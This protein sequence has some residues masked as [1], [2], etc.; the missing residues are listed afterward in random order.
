MKEACRQL[1]V[2]IRTLDAHRESEHTAEARECGKSLPPSETQFFKDNDLLKMGT[3]SQLSELLAPRNASLQRT[4]RDVP[5]CGVRS[6]LL[7]IG[8]MLWL[9]V[10]GTVF[11]AASVSV[12]PTSITYPTVTVGLGAGNVVYV[13]NTGSTV[14]TITKVNVTP[15]PQFYVSDGLAPA[16][17]YPGRP[18]HYSIRFVPAAAQSYSGQ[19]QAFLSDGSNV[20]VP[21]SGTGVTTN[22]VASLSTPSVNFVNQPLGTVSGPQ[23][24]TISDTGSDPFKIQA[25]RTFPPFTVSGFSRPVTVQPGQSS[26]VL[27]RFFGS[28][29]GPAT[30]TLTIFYDVLPPNGLTLSGTATTSGSLAATTFPTLPNA[31]QGSAYSATLMAAGGVPPYSWSLAQGSSLPLGL[32]LSSS[33][34]INGSIDPTVV[35]GNYFLTVQLTD[36]ASPPTVLNRPLTIAVAAP[37]GANCNEITYNDSANLNQFTPITDLGTGTYQGVQGGLYPGGTNVRP[38]DHNAY[39]VTLANNIQPLDLNG[40]PDPNGKYVLLSVGQSDNQ[41]SFA[42]FVTNASADPSTAPHLVVVDGGQG[43]AAAEPLQ[44]PNN[45]HWDEIVNSLLPAAGVSASQVV[46]VWLMA[47]DSPPSGTFTNH[48]AHLQNEL[49]TIVQIL[50]TKFPNLVLTYLS[51]RYYAGYSNGI[52][53][54]D[55]EPYSYEQGFAIKDVIQDQ[56][57]G[58]PSLNFDPSVGPVFSPWLSWG[59]YTWANGLLPRSDGLVWTC[60]DLRS[61]G[62][63]TVL[64]GSEK[65]SNLLMNFFRTD[66]TTVPWFLAH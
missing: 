50:H 49:E 26:K 4:E 41:I 7:H 22:A 40:N 51:S 62:I 55:P 35:V 24:V 57:S 12:S 9:V 47:I 20:V 6:A 65:E 60:Q 32:A 44:D 63:H 48:V 13:T 34:I 36:S 5:P 43:Q 53:G 45:G 38:S 11:A 46:A 66:D 17:A 19:F 33:G 61:D 37:T 25:V 28:A 30:G 27:V 16:T 8:L 2:R 64:P 52:R 31:T 54:T 29:V 18:V 56:L 42:Q 10:T 23:I 3:L 1:V 39:G 21:L 15:F 59:P 58:A 14:L